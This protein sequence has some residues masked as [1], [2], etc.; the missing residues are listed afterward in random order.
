[1]VQLGDAPV[2]YLH[3]ILLLWNILTRTIEVMSMNKPEKMCDVKLDP[4]IRQF[5]AKNRQILNIRLYILRH[6]R[7]NLRIIMRTDF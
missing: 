2:Y 4:H 1:M 6:S 3:S 7:I 5:S